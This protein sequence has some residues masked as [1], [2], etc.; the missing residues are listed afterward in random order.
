[1]FKALLIEKL[2][3]TLFKVNQNKELLHEQAT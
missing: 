3:A 2:F 1:M